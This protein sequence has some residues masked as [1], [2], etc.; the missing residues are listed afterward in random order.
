MTNKNNTSKTRLRRA[1]GKR[2][3][4][5][6]GV[7]G[8]FALAGCGSAVAVEASSTTSNSSS[9]TATASAAAASTGAASGSNA[10]SVNAEG[11]SV[12]TVSGLTSS[13]FTL[14]T[15][16]G[17]KYTVKVSS[18]TIDEKGAVKD[19]ETALVLGK[20]N[21]TTITAEQI[22]ADPSINLKTASA[23]VLAFQQ[24]SQSADKSVGSIP[25]DYKEGSGTIM[26]GTTANKAATAALS[27]YAGGIVDRVV[28]LS[29]GE[30]EV[31]YIGVN[32][33]HHIF[34]SK[35]FKV[36]GAD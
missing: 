32:W 11:G 36:L 9:S 12:G 13:G 29:N 23:S 14:T 1:I 2:R 30:Y 3:W 17:A 19:T 24:G 10:R 21:N 16:T 25:S 15:P 18:S 5:V 7:T 33:P 31:H 4:V 26:K 35:S 27:K 22:T 20:V 28:K 8:A 34:V 6:L